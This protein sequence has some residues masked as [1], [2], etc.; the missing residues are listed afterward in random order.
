MNNIVSGSFKGLQS[1]ASTCS[2]YPSKATHLPQSTRRASWR[3]EGP[4]EARGG[5][6]LVQ[7]R[8]GERRIQRPCA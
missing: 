6:Q 1:R 7:A 8:A 2:A 4:E 3:P 5:E